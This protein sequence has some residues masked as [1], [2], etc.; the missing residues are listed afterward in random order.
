M[1]TLFLCVDTFFV[2]LPQSVAKATERQTPKWLLL[3]VATALAWD[4]SL[5]EKSKGLA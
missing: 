4:K 3:I 1:G 2:F 5:T